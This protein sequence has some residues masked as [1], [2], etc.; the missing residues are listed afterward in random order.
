MALAQQIQAQK[1]TG[2]QL[3][4]RWRAAAP[5][6]F[7]SPFY[8]IFL[9]FGLLPILFS[10]VVSV[11]DWRGTTPGGYVGLANYRI[12]LNDPSFYKALFNTFYVWVGS[13][14]TMIFLALIFAVFLNSRLVRFRSVFRTLY[15]LPVVTS[16]LIAGLIFSLL[17]STSFGLAN[18]I[19]ELVGIAPINWLADPNWMKV[20]L[21]LALLWRWTG[22]DM[23]L[24][25]AGLQ[26]IPTDL[27]EAAKVD[28]ATE[29]QTFWHITVPLM[30]PVILFDAIISTIGAFNL[31]AEPFALF[32]PGGGIE[33]SGLVTGTL[34]YQYAFVYFKFGY[35]SALAWVLAM[36]IFALSMIQL[37]LGNRSVD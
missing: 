6:V 32:G 29:V 1:T 15:F 10:L 36:V 13:V 7:I 18:R 35:G 19:L 16:L 11:F 34:L 12:L 8:I 23:V 3:D 28:G 26:Q 30:R 17:F 14:P 25:L 33:Q 27:Y 4:R 31:F 24:M 20:T 5:Y 9:A 21:I 2:W 22:N 37:R